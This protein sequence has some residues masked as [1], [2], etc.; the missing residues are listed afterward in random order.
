MSSANSTA[1]PFPFASPFDLSA[2]TG[3]LA[4]GS[5]HEQL[6]LTIPHTFWYT[7]DRVRFM[8]NPSASRT[9]VALYCLRL[10]QARL[11]TLPAIAQITQ[12]YTLLLGW[13]RQDLIGQIPRWSYEPLERRRRLVLRGVRTTDVAWA[14]HRILPL[15]WTHA[16]VHQACLLAGLVDGPVGKSQ[17]LLAA[18]IERA[19]NP[20]I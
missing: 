5:R 4:D 2:I 19:G 18:C 3:G 17:G 7:L 1:H 12:H 10:G 8:A 14:T 20:S 15:G 11:S 13:G 16:E 9:D 6:S